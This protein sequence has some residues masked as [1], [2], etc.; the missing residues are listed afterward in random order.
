MGLKQISLSVCVAAVFF[1]GEPNSAQEI[2]TFRGHAGPITSLGFSPNGTLLATAGEDGTLIIWDVANKRESY[3]I[4]EKGVFGSVVFSKDSKIVLSL[5]E[6]EIR[7]LELEN[8]KVSYKKVNSKGRAIG[9]SPNSRLLVM[10]GPGHVIII[11][12]LVKRTELLRLTGHKKKVCYV[13]F[14]P[15]GKTIASCSDDDTMRLWD[16]VSKKEVARINAVEPCPWTAPLVFTPDGMTIVSGWRT[17]VWDVR[18]RRLKF[19]LPQRDAV[20]SVAVSPTGKL[21]ATGSTDD[22]VKFW[23]TKSGKE[24]LVFRHSSG[25][26]AL[27]FSP[28]GQVLAIAGGNISDGMEPCEVKLISVAG[29]IKK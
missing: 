10:E 18:T 20:A 21:L 8:K 27:A 22:V 28:D 6:T 7:Y 16:L 12:D 13:A 14:S 1:L 2:A 25:A 29:L 15:N 3:R 23:E 19:K 4:Q 24:L 5:S 11:E 9:F 17:Q 26:L